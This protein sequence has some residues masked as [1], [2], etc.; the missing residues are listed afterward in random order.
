MSTQGALANMSDHL[1]KMRAAAATKKLKTAQQKKE[2]AQRLA[3]NKMKAKGWTFAA[4]LHTIVGAEEPFRFEIVDTPTPLS[5]SAEDFTAPPKV[6]TPPPP[7]PPTPPKW[8][9]HLR[10][11]PLPHVERP[12]QATALQGATAPSVGRPV[13]QP[14]QTTVEIP[15]QDAALQE[16]TAPSVERPVMQPAQATVESPVQG[17]ALQ[18]A[19]APILQTPAAAGANTVS[20]PGLGVEQYAGLNRDELIRLLQMQQSTAGQTMEPA[21]K[22]AR[23]TNKRKAGEPAGTE[24]QQMDDRVREKLMGVFK[25]MRT[26]QKMSMPISRSDDYVPPDNSEDE[27]DVIVAQ[28][29]WPKVIHGIFCYTEQK[30][31]EDGSNGAEG[32]FL[33][34]PVLY[35]NVGSEYMKTELAAVDLGMVECKVTVDMD[36]Y[37]NL[38]RSESAKKKPAPPPPLVRKGNKRKATLPKM[39]QMP[40]MPPMPQMPQMP[41]FDKTNSDDDGD[42]DYVEV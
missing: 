38:F 24:R 10:K 39:P 7:P 19:M 20:P 21:K 12:V 18:E 6:A 5:L 27:D 33:R 16:A 41:K 36:E 26:T 30:A 34:N 17:A 13:M 35:M 22:K 15:V 37:F 31:N 1:T 14:A 2:K 40:Q 9:V 23:K 28:K 42:S 4:T 32:T 11:A 8:T 3:V 25:P 29:R